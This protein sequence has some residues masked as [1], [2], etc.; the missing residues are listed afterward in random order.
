MMREAM[1]NVRSLGLVEVSQG[2]RAVVRAMTAEAAAV[3]LEA[4]LSG[5][6]EALFYLNE[7]RQALELETA[8][9]AARRGRSDGLAGLFCAVNQRRS[10]C[11]GRRA[12]GSLSTC[13]SNGGDATCALGTG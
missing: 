5:N 10:G 11:R 2:R 1:R 13:G 8:T 4:L 12:I 9:L 3:S 6:A 7:A